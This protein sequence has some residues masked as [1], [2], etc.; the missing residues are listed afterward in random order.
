M[1]PLIIIPVRVAL[2]YCALSDVPQNEWDKFIEM[3]TSG[4]VQIVPNEL[5]P[6]AN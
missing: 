3:V 5:V 6:S 1:S 4:E 2:E